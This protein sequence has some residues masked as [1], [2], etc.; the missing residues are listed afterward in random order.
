MLV[1][2]EVHSLAVVELSGIWGVVEHLACSW[3][4]CLRSAPCERSCVEGHIVLGSAH[5]LVVQIYLGRLCSLGK[6][7]KQGGGVDLN[8]DGEV[9][10]FRQ[11][12]PPSD[13][14]RSP[15]WL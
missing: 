9:N 4:G 7:T 10:A 5:Y 3:I 12:T 8:V 6:L 15:P 13:V 11:G 2:G 14:A 1:L